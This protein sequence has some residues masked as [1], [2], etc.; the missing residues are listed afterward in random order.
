MGVKI[1]PLIEESKRTITFENLIGKKIAIDAFNTLYQFLAIIR[2]ADGTPLKDLEGNVTS[3]LSGLFYRTINI[4]EKDIKPIF[5]FDGPPNPLK[6]KEIERRRAVRE[7]A[8]KL[9]KEAQD[10]GQV[11]DAHKYAQATSRLNSEMIAESKEFIMA[12]GLPIVEAPQDGEAQAAALVNSGEAYA[13]GSQDY[14]SLLFGAERIVRNISQSRTRKVHGRTVKVDLEWINLSKVLEQNAITQ[15]QLVDIGILTGVDFFEGIEGIGA[16]TGIK[17][18]KDH[19]SIDNL[20]NNKIEFHGTSF[21]ELLNIEL[22]QQVRGI[23]LQ[24]NVTTDVHPKW[25]NPNPEKMKEILCEKHNFDQERVNSALDR[26]MTQKNTE[27]QLT[28]DSFFKRK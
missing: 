1:S 6:M 25:S 9:M 12:M 7:D 17:L 18:I 21:S 11:E 10:L 24:Q 28:M 23:F 3:H 22:I 2:G 19:G 14:D 4:L 26:L 15:E 8:T 20:I 5:V 27:T 16:K 13:V